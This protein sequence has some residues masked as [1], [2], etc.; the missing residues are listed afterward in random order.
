MSLADYAFERYARPGV[1]DLML[2]LQD[3]HGQSV[4][5]LLWAAWAQTADPAVT[6]AAAEL[7]R[8]WE[9]G[10]TGPLR[11][12]RRALAAQPT[13]AAQTVKAM[14]QESELAAETL[15]LDV[16][17]ALPPAPSAPMAEA[18]RITAAT[19]RDDAPLALLDD[20]AKRLA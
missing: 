1:K 9:A 19:W 3:D 4:C 5:L 20:L 2:I 16:L 11:Q 15:L 12:A 14:V 8:S 10:V 17:G 13:A 6:R 18:L 7:A